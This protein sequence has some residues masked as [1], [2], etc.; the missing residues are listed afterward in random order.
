M[1][2]KENGRILAIHAVESEA[3]L[4][5][6]ETQEIRDTFLQRCAAAAVEGQFAVDVGIEGNLMIERAA[7][8]DLMATNLTFATELTSHTGLSSGVDALIKRCPR[9]VLVLAGDQHS[10]MD[11]ALLAYDGSPK[12]DEALFVATYLALR[13][14][15]DLTVVTVRTKH[16]P[17]AALERARLYLTGH[18][19]SQVEYV[20][21]ERPI[22]AAIM[23]T[24]AER[25]CNLLIIGGYGI[26][27]IRHMAL[28]STVTDA[29][30]APNQPILI[31]R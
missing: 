1:A 14:Q 31:C 18:H 20:L 24:A 2:G 11:R 26:R 16:T 12:A 15:I 19:L 3:G 30:Q 5:S 10:A 17:P 7:W 29:L 9:P 6:A 28:G 25:N 13:W 27:N 4:Q 8:V 21:Q 22:T 23:N